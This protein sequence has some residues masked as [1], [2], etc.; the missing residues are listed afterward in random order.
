[1]TTSTEIEKA[2]AQATEEEA[3]QATSRSRLLRRAGAQGSGRLLR[4]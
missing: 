2:A 3:T 4:P 1:M